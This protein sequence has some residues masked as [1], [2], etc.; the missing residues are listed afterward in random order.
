MGC[1]GATID[2]ALDWANPSCASDEAGE[3]VREGGAGRGGGWGGGRR[4]AGLQ[5]WL[6]AGVGAWSG[7]EVE[8]GV[9]EETSFCLD[10]DGLGSASFT[11][12][13]VVKGRGE[14]VVGVLSELC[15]GQGGG[16]CC[17][18]CQDGA[19]GVGEGGG[20]KDVVLCPAV[21]EE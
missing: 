19:P 6:G 18:G 13:K 17:R 7:G 15:F 8:K 4:G 20:L 3:E 11:C 9:R 1:A 2:G 5:V 10:W 14:G 16:E 12:P 21:A